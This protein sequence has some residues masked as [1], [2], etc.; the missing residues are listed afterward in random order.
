MMLL[1]PGIYARDFAEYDQIDAINQSSLCPISV[2]PLHY[3]AALTAE[4]KVRPPMRLGDVAHC[5]VLEPDQLGK[6]Y[7]VWCRS[8]GVE[9]FRG[10]EYDAFRANAELH[11]KRVIKQSE[12]DAAMAMA[13]AVRRSRLAQRYLSRGL[14]EQT[15]VWRDEPTGLLCKGRVDW[16]SHAVADVGVELKTTGSITPR[17]FEPRFA[18]AQ[19][20]VQM[21]FYADGFR[22]VTGRSLGCKCVVVESAPPFDVGVYDLTEAID[23]GRMYY[24]EML[25]RL[26]E[27]LRTN[28][29]PGQLADERSLRLPFWR[30]NPDGEDEDITDV[31]L[32][33]GT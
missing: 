3:R 5:A 22:A 23:T 33:Y 4:R 7:A 11:G 29:W 30:T 26:V 31:D 1:E 24:R 21:A 10:K 8:D 2:S 18:R 14:P 12:L 6:R 25:T 19:Y 32:D 20:D 15:I 16:L 9:D 27:C 13:A 17:D 28:E